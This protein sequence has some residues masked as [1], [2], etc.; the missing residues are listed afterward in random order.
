MGN[1]FESVLSA[2]VLALVVGPLTAW[3]VRRGA[4]ERKS[5][6]QPQ[7]LYRAYPQGIPLDPGRMRRSL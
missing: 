4:K 1:L 2:A 7:P 3:I 5:T 6:R